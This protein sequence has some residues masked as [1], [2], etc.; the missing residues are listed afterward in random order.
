[1]NE[2]IGKRTY[3]EVVQTEAKEKDREESSELKELQ[4]GS[5]ASWLKTRIAKYNE[6]FTPLI[7]IPPD[8]HVR[9]AIQLIPGALPVMKHLYR[10]SAEQKKSADEQIHNAMK[11]G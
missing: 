1:M 4:M 6:L 7:D 8:D 10:L 2:S 5:I 3:L 11:E 9:H